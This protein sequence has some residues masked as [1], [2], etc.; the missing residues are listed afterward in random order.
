M[1]F[2]KDQILKLIETLGPITAQD[3][4]NRLS[5]LANDPI[6]V[7]RKKIRELIIDDKIPIASS[8]NPPAGYFIAK[9]DARA[10]HYAAQLKSR[11][12]AISER[13]S[14]F[15]HATAKQIQLLLIP[16]QEQEK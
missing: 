6:R 9:Q 8:M 11:I 12:F 1:D 7:I 3:I 16:S 14:A 10:D 5:I 13:L 4:N 15:E 2:L